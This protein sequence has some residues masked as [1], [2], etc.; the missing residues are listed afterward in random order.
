MNDKPRKPRQPKL[1]QHP[2]RRAL[3][4][5]P[6]VIGRRRQETPRRRGRSSWPPQPPQHPCSQRGA[7][8]RWP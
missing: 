3:P 4:R 1:T 2:L 6:R 7:P 5:R 8:R